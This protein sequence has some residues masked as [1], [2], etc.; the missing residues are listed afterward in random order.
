MSSST[1]EPLVEAILAPNPTVFTGKGTNTYVV[2]S[3]DVVVLDPGPALDSHLD[4]VRAAAKARGDITAVHLTHHHAD[5]AEAARS[6]ADSVAAP[7]CTMPHPE[8][9]VPSRSLGEG[10]TVTFGGGALVAWHTPGHCRDH[11]CF[12][13]DD[14]GTVFGGDLVAT[15]G[16]IIV[17]PP[18]GD[19]AQYMES[20]ERVRRHFAARGGGRL[21]PGHGAPIDDPV[22]HLDRYIAHRRERES[23]VLDAIRQLGAP[24]AA[25]ILPVAYADTPEQMYPLASRSLAAHLDKLVLEGTAW[26]DG[27]G[28]GAH[29]RA[30]D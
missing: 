22:G 23:R 3:G 28:D 18:D 7:L 24:T 12:A 26:R 17:D 14:G 29:Y 25:E 1:A 2:G 5:H 30:G 9:P 8:G 16:F 19:M 6:F 4:R 10:D 11:L 21:L 27:D 20:L 13:T 15:E